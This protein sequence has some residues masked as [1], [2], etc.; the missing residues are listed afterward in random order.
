MM[1]LEDIKKGIN[2]SLKEI[3]ENSVKE[4]ETLKE[5]TQKSLKELQENIT[6]EVMELNKTIHDPKREVETINKNLSETTL[7]IETLGKKSG[8]IDRASATEYN[9]WKRESQV[10]KI[11]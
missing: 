3:Q 10:Q 11:P 6:K 8:M 7:G 2:D 5:E 9:R 1:L 4:V